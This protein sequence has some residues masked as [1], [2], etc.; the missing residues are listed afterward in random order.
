MVA[1][2]HRAHPGRDSTPRREPMRWGGREEAVDQRGNL[3]A[4]S[5]AQAPGHMGYRMPLLPSNGPTAPPGGASP[6]PHQSAQPSQSLAG[7]CSR[8]KIVWFNL[9]P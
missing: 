2:Q 3:Q 1:V 4:P 9:T 5:D 6:R 7:L 8:A